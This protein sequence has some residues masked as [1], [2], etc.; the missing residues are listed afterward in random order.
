MD[1]VFG[2]P[3]IYVTYLSRNDAKTASPETSPATNALGSQWLSFNGAWY[4]ANIP[5]TLVGL[6]NTPNTPAYCPITRGQYTM[7][8]YEHMLVR[9]TFASDTLKKA[10]RD[11]ALVSLNAGDDAI[12][13]I[14]L[15]AMK[16]S[17]S[18]DGA[19]PSLL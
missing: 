19:V 1:G 18:G 15:N 14:S 5:T 4:F 11:A 7:W 2:N 9:S 12:S 8:S 16:V 13:G 3:L 10:L 6:A 17:R